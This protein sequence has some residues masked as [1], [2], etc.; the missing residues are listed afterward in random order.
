MVQLASSKPTVADDNDLENLHS[1]H[2]H[3]MKDLSAVNDVLHHRSQQLQSD[4]DLH[5]DTLDQTARYRRDLEKAVEEKLHYQQE[6]DRLKREKDQINQEKIEYK[7]KYDCLQEEIRA[8]LLDR[9]KLEQQLTGELQEQIQQRQRSKDDLHKYKAQIE[10]VNTKLSD[11]EARLSVLQTQN[12][13]LS[14][15][16]DRNSNEDHYETFPSRVFERASQSG[17]NAIPEPRSP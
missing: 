13:A 14:S 12:D 1:R 7:I 10:Q 5:K 4:V 17:S 3:Q 8:I 9:S 16:K 15:T 2:R 6:Y 11:A